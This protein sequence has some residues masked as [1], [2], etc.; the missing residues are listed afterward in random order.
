MICQWQALWQIIDLR[1]TG[2]S[3][4]FAITEFNNCFIIGSWPSLFF[5]EYFREA[6]RSAIFHPSVTARRRKAWYRLRMSRI[7]FA[8]KHNPDPSAYGQASKAILLT[9]ARCWGTPLLM[10][11]MYKRDHW[12]AW[13]YDSS[14]I[15]LSLIF[16][17]QLPVWESN[18]LRLQSWMAAIATCEERV[19]CCTGWRTYQM[20]FTA[21]CW[22]Q[23]SDF[24]VS[25]ST[26]W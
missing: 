19:T 24:F 6:K 20:C 12:S 16:F 9:R 1:D 5:N 21:A 22:G 18:T 3:R 13:L 15:K 8:T 26:V 11:F 14:I 7:L 23:G 17:L 4:H 25:Q 2:K 10:S